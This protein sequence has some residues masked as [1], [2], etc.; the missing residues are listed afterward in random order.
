MFNVDIELE[1]ICSSDFFSKM[2]VKNN[3]SQG[4][5]YVP[6]VEAAFVAPSD[7]DF[8]G[9]YNE[10]E[11]LPTAPTQDDPFYKFPKFPKE[12]AD[13]RLRINKAVMAATRGLDKSLFK[14]GP[15]DFS[16]AAR[17]GICYAFR[18]Y[19]AEQYFSIGGS[20]ELIVDMY[21]SGRWPVGYYQNGLVLI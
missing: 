5:I 2:G 19:A 3:N 8:I 17:N 12:L 6:S 10:V 20:W 21:Y 14:S 13:I 16:I 1:K 18:Q 7:A 9:K 15:H 11:W 4:F